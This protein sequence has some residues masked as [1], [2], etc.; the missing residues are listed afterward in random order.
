MSKI[1]K[2][3]KKSRAALLKGVDMLANAV[4]VTLGAKGRNVIIKRKFG[5]PHI[6]KDGVT[7]AREIESS[8]NSV[9]AGI[10]VIRGAATKTVEDA[11]DGTT[12]STVLAQ[13]IIHRGMSAIDEGYNPIGVKKGIDLAVKF[14]VEKLAKMSEVVGDNYDRIKQIASISANNDEEIGGLISDTMKEVGRNGIISITQA[15]STETSTTFVEGMQ[16]E[17]GYLSPYFITDQE[18]QEVVLENPYIL[19][20]EGEVNTVKEGFLPWVE[21]IASNNKSLLIIADDVAG[22]AL[23]TLI[24]NKV[25]A[26]LKVAVVKS[27]EMGKYKTQA[28][29]DIAILTGGQV[30]TN[31]LGR[32]LDEFNA[33]YYGTAAKVTVNSN[34]TTIIDGGGDTKELAERIASIHNLIEGVD[35]DY[36]QIKQR[37]RL[38]KLDGKTAVIRVGGGSEVE[39]K[40]RKDRFDD[41]LG[42][43]RSAVEEGVIVGGGVALLRCSK[44][45]EIDGLVAFDTD[46]EKKG[47]EI[48]SDAIRAPFLQIA[49]NAGVDG[50]DFVKEILASENEGWGYNAK[51]D[52]CEDLKAKGIFDPT[53]VCRVALENAAS[54]ASMLITTECLI[55]EKKQP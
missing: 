6:T 28:L 10:D 5:A 23:G 7:V 37:E 12:T 53:K 8:K 4:K 13:A 11:D 47:I 36:E 30:I 25:N 38:S 45:L 46:D 41:A 26:G 19:L 55:V 14:I 35:N 24:I 1:I 20:I 44:Q 29:E 15:Q 3:N 48:V 52:I 49:H 50:E 43:A 9:Q 33:D 16:F 27:P 40:E 34:R 51:D 18:K 31:V 42:A 22:E 17:R 54:V 32:R 39:I 2:Y 21:F